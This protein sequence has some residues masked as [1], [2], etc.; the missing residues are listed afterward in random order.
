MRIVSI[1]SFYALIHF[2]PMSP[3]GIGLATAKRFLQSNIEGLLLIDLSRESLEKA[4]SSF[5]PDEQRRCEMFVAD[6]SSEAETTYAEKALERWGRL[7]IAVLNAGICLPR[8]SIL[9][10]EVD[11][12]DKIMNVNGRGV[13]LGLKN[14]AKAMLKKSSGSIVI[15]SSQLGLQG[16]PGLSAYGASKWAELTPLGIRVNSICPGPILTPLI[17]ALGKDTWPKMAEATLMN[18][19]GK[20]DE[21]ANA[22]LYLASDAA[23]FCSGTTLKVDGGYTKSG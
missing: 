19:L 16:S 11:T 8:A 15:I 6:V 5:T 3:G 4:F 22:V 20:P 17:D 18:R 23:S 14:C 12:W 9:D 21:I 7:D 10:T 13:F 2:S 1:K